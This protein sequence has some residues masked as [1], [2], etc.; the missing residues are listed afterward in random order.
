MTKLSDYWLVV[1]DKVTGEFLNTQ[2][3]DVSGK[4]VDDVM[5]RFQE[6]NTRYTAVDCGEG[7]ENRPITIREL[8][9]IS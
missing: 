5:D 8:P 4:S 1:V 6:K 7:V 3:T 2:V 9:Y